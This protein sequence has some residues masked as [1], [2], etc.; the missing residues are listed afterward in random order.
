MKSFEMA[1]AERRLAGLIQIG[2]IESV[3][4]AAA[5]A[6][7]RVGAILTAA[8]PMVAQRAG[9]DRAWWPY[10][11][12]EQVCVLAPSGDLAQGVIL[13]AIYSSAAPPNGDQAGID[14]RS[15]QDGTVVEYDRNSG[16]LR[17]ALTSGRV[18]IT[19]PGGVNITGNVTVVGDVVADGIS[20]TG[21]T[22]SGVRTGP[23][24][25]GGPQ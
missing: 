2:T 14:R 22:H 21:H 18:E 11:A 15:Y 4:Y 17:A 25:T 1:E 13:G 3:D 16:V 8:L 5:T 23:S 7:V 20:L 12:G 9:K 6:R 10:E 24:S 19:A